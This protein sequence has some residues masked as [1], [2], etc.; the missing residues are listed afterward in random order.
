MADIGRDV[1]GTKTTDGTDT[2]TLI[3]Y[4]DGAILVKVNTDTVCLTRN[5]GFVKLYDALAA[6]LA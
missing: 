4:G 6:A 1:I 5:E 2:I 3:K